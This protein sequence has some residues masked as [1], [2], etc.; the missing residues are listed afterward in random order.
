MRKR[1]KASITDSLDLALELAFNYKLNPAVI[2]ACKNLEQ[3]DNYLDCLE[4][5]ELEKFNYFEVKYEF[6]PTKK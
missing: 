4:L 1:E 5:D 6:L 2:L 3:L